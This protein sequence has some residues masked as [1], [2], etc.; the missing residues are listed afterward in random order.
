MKTL[1][2]IEYLV[3][4]RVNMWHKLHA[5]LLSQIPALKKSSLAIKKKFNNLFKIYKEDKLANNISGE[6]RH[7]CKYYDLSEISFSK[8]GSVLKHVSVVANDLDMPAQDLVDKMD[9]GD[10]TDNTKNKSSTTKAS[11]KA[12]SHDEALVLFGKMVQTSE[13]LLASFNCTT[14]VLNKQMDKLIEKL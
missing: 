7:E 1:L 8:T 10:S 9:L 11:G 5:R 14:D 13:G 12:K 6:S 3:F 2:I 4:A